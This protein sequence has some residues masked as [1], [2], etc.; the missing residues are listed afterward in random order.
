MTIHDVLKDAPKYLSQRYGSLNKYVFEYIF[1]LEYRNRH[2]R[3]KNAEER[4]KRIEKMKRIAEEA[5]VFVFI[6]VLKKTFVEGS[7]AA[8]NT[9]DIFKDLGV[10]GF[11]LGTTEFVD[12]NENVVMGDN[13]AKKMDQ[14]L[15]LKVNEELSD[16]THIYEILNVYKGLR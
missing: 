13:L 15:N 6:Y 8:K 11:R 1:P 4:K 12:R 14:E 10:D 9:V 7:M 2:L 16:A 3:I 5:S